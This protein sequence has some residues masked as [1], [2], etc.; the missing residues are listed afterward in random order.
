MK[1]KKRCNKLL[2]LLPTISQG[3]N[4]KSQIFLTKIDPGDPSHA[5]PCAMQPGLLLQ[6]AN[7]RDVN[8]ELHVSSHRPRE[9]GQS[10]GLKVDLMIL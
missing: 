4:L 7:L 5:H 2:I 10:A 6:K 1:Q 8:L 9:M 3:R